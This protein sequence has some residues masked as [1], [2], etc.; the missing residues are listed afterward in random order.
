M[1]HYTE[2]GLDNV[3][4]VNGVKH[5]ETPYGDGVAIK[6]VEGLHRTIGEWLVTLPKR[7]NGAELRFV[8]TEMDLSQKRMAALLGAEEQALRRW[9]KTR[10]KPIPGTPDRLVRGL[11]AEYLGSRCPVRDLVERMAELDEID[12]IDARLRVSKTGWK[13]AA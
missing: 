13:L 7:W 11:Y 1:Y 2:S 4:L 5:H 10:S 8:R 3:W 6:N 9:E 12:A